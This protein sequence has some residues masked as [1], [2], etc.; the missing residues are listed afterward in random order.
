MPLSSA[1]VDLFLRRLQAR[2][3]LT[4]VEQQAIR[5]LNYTTAR[6]PARRDFVLPG[7]R[8]EYVSLIA[9]GVAARFDLLRNGRRAIGELFVRGDVCDLTSLVAPRAGWGL[10]SLSP[11]QILH[12]PHRSLRA[13][14]QA[15]PEIAAAFWRDCAADAGVLAKW[16]GNMGRKNAKA[17]IAHLL[18][19]MAIRVEATGFGTRMRYDLNITQD[20]IADAMGLTGMHVNRTLNVLREE[21]VADVHSHVVE[22]INWDRLAYIADFDETFLLLDQPENARLFEGR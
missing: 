22:V 7:Q 12:I 5:Q 3:K 20:Q 2:S 14:M 19:E 18:C 10:T 1:A 15:H 8:V 6:L 13:L 21:G 4:F 16:V 9:D 17:R 11:V